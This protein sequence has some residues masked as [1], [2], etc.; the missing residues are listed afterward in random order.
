MAGVGEASI[1]KAGRDLESACS[2]FAEGCCSAGAG[3]GSAVM[4]Q[5]GDEGTFESI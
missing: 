2:V 4:F 3:D 1:F 5:D